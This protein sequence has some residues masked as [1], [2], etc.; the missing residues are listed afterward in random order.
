MGLWTT[1]ILVGVYH[2][3]KGTAIFKMVVDFQGQYMYIYIY[4]YVYNLHWSYFHSM[5]SLALLK[6]GQFHSR[7]STE[8]LDLFFNVSIRHIHLWDFLLPLHRG[9]GDNVQQPK[10][11]KTV[12]A[13]T[14]TTTTTKND[15]YKGNPYWSIW[16]TSSARVGRSEK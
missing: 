13:T 1:I 11:G 15:L 10:I 9:S 6:I 16:S 7:I 3:P 12:A 4:K 14:T 8:M 2:H 5:C